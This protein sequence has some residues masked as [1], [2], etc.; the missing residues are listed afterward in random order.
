MYR[1]QDKTWD[2]FETILMTYFIIEFIISVAVFKPPRS[3]ML[4]DWGTYI[5]VI[6]ILPRLTMLIF[7]IDDTNR[8]SFFRILRI[9]KIFRIM[10]ILKFLRKLKSRRSNSELSFERPAMSPLTNHILILVVSLLSTLFISAGFVIF[11]DDE[12]DNAWTFN[13]NYIDAIYYITVTGSTLG[14]GDIS[15]IRAISRFTIIFVIVIIIYIF[16]NQVKQIIAI[17]YQDDS[18]DKKMHL[19]NHVVIF[20]YNDNIE[21]LTSF[22]LY[23]L[24]YEKEGLNLR[25]FKNGCKILLI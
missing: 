15:P 18:Y 5:D 20:L 23:Y 12:V 7:N 4:Y 1:D 22:L 25:D 13:I 17:L 21:I 8:F 11:I 19:K 24:R 10:R 2:V 3:R 16:A 14:Y 6:T 9:F